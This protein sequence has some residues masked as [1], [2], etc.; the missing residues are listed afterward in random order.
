[1]TNAYRLVQW[2]AHKKTY[3]AVLAASCVGFLV[4]FVGVS[5]L[6]HRAPNEISPPVLLIR[7]LAVLAFILLHVILVIGPLARLTDRVA[8]LLYNRRHLGVTF[9]IVA[10]LHALLATL[11]YG[12]FGVRN[13]LMAALDSGGSF[14]SVSGFPFEM[15]GFA[16]LLVF[17]MMAATSHDFWLANLSPRVWKTLHMLVYPAYALVVLHVVLGAMQSE[18]SPVGAVLL[19]AGAL[20]VVS[21]HVAAGVLETRTDAAAEPVS[22]GWIT[23]DNPRAIPDGRARVV[24]CPGGTRVAVFRDGDAYSAVSNVC[25][26]QGGPLGEGAVIGGC[27][28][29][30]W[31]GYQYDAKTGQSPPPYTEKIPTYELRVRGAALELR[32]EPLAPGTPTA[33]AVLPPADDGDAS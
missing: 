19:A 9:F 1:M 17:F 6:T 25:A 15:L 4:V 8:P 14:A 30:P 24:V 3:D 2:N 10:L 23:V 20:S 5:M 33:P 11:F 22:D 12:G 29:C 27:V 32:A 18:T 28:T 16:A 26:H 21:L 13:P 7:G 31:H